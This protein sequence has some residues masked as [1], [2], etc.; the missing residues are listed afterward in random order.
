MTGETVTVLRG[1]TVADR[2]GDT[3]VDWTTPART[4]VHGAFVAPR[5]STEAGNGRAGV[6]VG[7]TAYLPPGTRVTA[8]DRVEVRGV[9]YSV[10]GEPG[11]WRDPF[12]GIAVGIEV[13]LEAVHG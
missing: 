6:I 9:T 11:D 13:A 10:E 7:L 3:T 2:Y 1:V 5:S 4:T 12:D 8:A